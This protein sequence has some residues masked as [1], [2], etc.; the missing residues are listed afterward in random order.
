M[1]SQKEMLRFLIAGILVTATDFGIYFL[2]IHWLPFS[3]AKG[4][5]FTCAGILGYGLNKYWTFKQKQG[6]GSEMGRYWIVNFAALGINI[7]VNQM[8]IN[9]W[10]QQV[11]LAVVMATIVSSLVSYFCFKFWVFKVIPSRMA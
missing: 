2:L 8:M 4:T 9:T 7:F 6:S 3:V 1:N 10:P 11:G 5:S